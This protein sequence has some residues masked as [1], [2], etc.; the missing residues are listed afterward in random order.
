MCFHDARIAKEELQDD[1]TLYLRF[2]GIWG[3]E[4]EVWFW[5]DLD[6]DISSRDP[7]TCDPYWFGL[8]VILQ[9]GFVYF[10]DDD[11]MSSIARTELYYMRFCFYETGNR[12]QSGKGSLEL[13]GYGVA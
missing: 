5:G 7:E 6:Y 8:T 3:C 12:C 9:D 2:D 1:G 10:V 4:I 11:D 13:Y